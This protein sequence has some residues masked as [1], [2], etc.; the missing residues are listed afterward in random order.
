MTFLEP[1]PRH[2]IILIELHH[3]HPY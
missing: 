1:F 3:V 2:L